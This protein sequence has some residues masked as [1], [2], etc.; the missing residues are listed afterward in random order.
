MTCCPKLPETTR[1]T[2]ALGLPGGGSAPESYDLAMTAEGGM[3]EL[4]LSKCKDPE[5]KPVGT[6]LCDFSSSAPH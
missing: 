1:M 3:A 2:L 6:S 5:S 4:Y